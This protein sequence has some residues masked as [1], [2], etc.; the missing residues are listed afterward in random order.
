M[1]LQERFGLP[2]MIQLELFKQHKFLGGSL[3]K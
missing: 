1:N 2:L 3:D